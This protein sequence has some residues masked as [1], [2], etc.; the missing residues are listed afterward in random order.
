MGEVHRIMDGLEAFS[1]EVQKLVKRLVPDTGLKSYIAL[2]YKVVV[3]SRM[4]RTIFHL[5]M[6]GFNYF[7]LWDDRNEFHMH[8]DESYTM[9]FLIFFESLVIFPLNAY[10]MGAYICIVQRW[11]KS[12]YD[13]LEP[14]YIPFLGCLSFYFFFAQSWVTDHH[15]EMHELDYRSHVNGFAG[16]Y[17]IHLWAD[18]TLLR[19]LCC[20]IVEGIEHADRGTGRHYMRFRL[21]PFV[22]GWRSQTGEAFFHHDVEYDLPSMFIEL[23][24]Y[25]LIISL[26]LIT[27]F[28]YET[29]WSMDW[30]HRHGYTWE[31]L[32]PKC[33]KMRRGK[34][35]KSASSSSGSSSDDEV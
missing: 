13:G 17:H 5:E 35:K 34:K 29:D 24:A 25:F 28:L 20:F 2:P 22:F 15:P 21:P 33:F 23:L 32:C 6:Q 8:G 19:I 18:F 14:W 30:R 16:C 26:T 31:K 11:I 9:L 7:P 1:V 27:F 3:L 12:R 10:C 4:F